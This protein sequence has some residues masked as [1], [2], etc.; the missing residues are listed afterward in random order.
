MPLLIKNIVR[1]SIG[2]AAVLVFCSLFAVGARAASL[3][4][5]IAYTQATGG[6]SLLGS[7]EA[8][9]ASSDALIPGKAPGRDTQSDKKIVYLTFDDGPSE[10]TDA[11]LSILRQNHIHGTFF[12]TSMYPQYRHLIKK[13]YD[14]GNTIGLHTA[15]HK[16]EIYRSEDTYFNDLNQIAQYVKSTIGFVPAYVRFPGGSSNTVSRNY[17]QGIM[18]KLASELNKRG[19]Q[20]YDWNADSTDAAHS[21]D[22]VD[23]LVKH[24]TAYNDNNVVLLCHDAPGKGTTVQAL[25]RI[26]DNYRSRGYTFKAISRNSYAPHQPIA[27]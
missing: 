27:N 22:N 26:I 11:I 20:Y 5:Y 23:D 25:Q 21:E 18:G 15:S 8:E 6:L 14:E 12:V 16:Y 4:S 19:Y 1:T 13:A 10:N 9:E 3:S 17:A 24:A 7:A 2:L